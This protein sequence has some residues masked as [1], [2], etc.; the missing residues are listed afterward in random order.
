MTSYRLQFGRN[1][2]RQWKKLDPDT[3]RQFSKKL[4]SI[5]ENPHIPSARLHGFRNS[6]RV[7]LR[8]VGYRLGYKVID[9]RLIVLVISVGRRDKDE[10]YKDFGQHYNEGY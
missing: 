4:E 5:L 10:A 6:Y 3:K 2:L 8:S 9:D 7:K 1:A